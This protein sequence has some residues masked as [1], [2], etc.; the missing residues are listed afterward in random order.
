M[1]RVSSGTNDPVHAALLADSGAAIPRA[2]SAFVATPEAPLEVVG[3]EARERGAGAGQDAHQ[4]SKNGT[5]A[6]GGRH[7][8]RIAGMQTG[9]GETRRRGVFVARENHAERLRQREGRHRDEDETQPVGQIESTERK[10]L[11]ARRLVCPDG[12]E[13]EA[14]QRGGQRP[15]HLPAIR[16]CCNAR[17]RENQDERVLRR[18]ERGRQRRERRCEQQERDGTDDAA[19]ERRVGG[20]RQRTPGLALSR[21]GI[22]VERCRHRRSNARRIDE[23][24][25]C[26]PAEDGAVV[27]AGHHDHACGGVQ[28][29]ADRD[30]QR[31]GGDGPEAGEHADER[32]GQAA[33]N[34]PR[35]VARIE[36]RG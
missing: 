13:H 9:M 2:P 4:E 24:R 5:A 11:Y 23:D 19:G 17:Q 6:H 25:R 7:G 27:D 18:L 32:A 31:D 35:E 1:P 16:E 36:R 12:A 15:Q 10:P 22:A 3:E 28:R 14:D 21:H 34:D 8:R 33:G 26:R 20:E 30:H 29:I